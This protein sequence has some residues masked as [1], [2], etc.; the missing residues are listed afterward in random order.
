MTNTFMIVNITPILY[1]KYSLE[2]NSVLFNPPKCLTSPF[3][4]SG[5]RIYLGTHLKKELND[6]F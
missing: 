5:E 1:V 3:S 2:D 4:L 6:L